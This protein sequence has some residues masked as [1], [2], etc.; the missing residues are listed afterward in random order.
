MP[1]RGLGRDLGLL[2]L[3]VLAV[4]AAFTFATLEQWR[5][6]AASEINAEIDTLRASDKLLPGVGALDPLIRRSDRNLG[7]YLIVDELGQNQGGNISLVDGRPPDLDKPPEFR[8]VLVGEQEITVYGRWMQIDSV[9]NVFISRSPRGAQQLI[10]V[11]GLILLMSTAAASI[12]MIYRMQQTERRRLVAEDKLLSLFDALGNGQ[13]LNQSDWNTDNQSLSRVFD[14]VG[15]LWD[16]INDRIGMFSFLRRFLQHDVMLSIDRAAN[17]IARR[18]GLD[19]DVLDNILKHIESSR[20]KY[21]GVMAVADFVLGKSTPF[22]DVDLKNQ[23]E[24]TLDELEFDIAHKKVEITTQ[25][26]PLR[27]LG[28]NGAYNLIFD[29]LLRNA[30][31]Y[32]D[33]G[34]TVSVTLQLA[35]DGR[36]MLMVRDCGPGTAGFPDDFNFATGPTRARRGPAQSRAHGHGF[37]LIIVYKLVEFLNARVSFKDRA[38]TRGLEVKV[39]FPAPIGSRYVSQEEMRS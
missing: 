26:A 39:T 6:S 35:P 21:N 18:D 30:I 33:P 19:E 10:L 24:R 36:P 11:V 25:L 28:L 38:N 2:I 27:G 17:V 3:A 29:N 1:L 12:I 20:N 32:T 23:I 4:F 15:P 34:S 22:E 31:A 8:R 9:L 13:A 5:V 37:G 7:Y 14:S 16:R